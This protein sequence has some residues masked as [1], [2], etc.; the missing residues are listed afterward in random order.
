VGDLVV[1]TAAEAPD[2]AARLGDI[3]DPAIAPFLYQDAVSIAL[4]D[5]VRLRCPE[6]TL[7]G[8]D[9]SQPRVPVAALYTVPFSWAPDPA[10]ELPA[11]G[12]DAVLLRAAEDQLTGRRGNL[13]SA[14]LAMV[15][16]EARG[17]GLS[18]LMLAAA[19]SNAA[20]LGHT[21]LVAPVRPTRKHRVPLVP[22][23]E[24]ATRVRPDGLP[25]DPWLRV[26]ARAGGRMVA[27]APCSMTVSAPLDR[28]RE[29]TGLPFDSAGPVVVPGGLTPVHC[30]P[31]E[32]IAVYVEPN[33]WYHH[34]VVDPVAECSINI[35]NCCL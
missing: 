13:V 33:V 28:W 32:E 1:T 19:R 7:I 14:V 20:A 15:R 11:G 18:A 5:A 24:Y 16:P 22:M 30:D 6:Y 2:L 29:W 17:R 21:C 27:V 3:E 26:H 10:V 23:S 31:A 34:R 12:Y 8:V 25:E 9:P 4:F 35:H